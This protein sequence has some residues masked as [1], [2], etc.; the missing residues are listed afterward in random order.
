M[1]ENAHLCGAVS[2][3]YGCSQSPHTHYAVRACHLLRA[4]NTNTTVWPGEFIEIDAPSELLTDATLAI[5]PRIDSVSSS[6]LKPTHTWPQTDIVQSIGGKLRL[7]NSTEEPL[8]VRK[9]DHLCQA[10][11]TVLESTS[12]PSSTQAEPSPKFNAPLSCS[13]ESVH[14]DPDGLLSPS[15][16][17]AFVSLLKEFQLVFDS[18]IPGYNGAAG[19]IEGVV[20]MGP[21][22]PPQRKGRVPQYSRDQLDL[23]QTKFDEL[24]SQGVFR[25][26]EDLKVVVEYLN[27]SFLV[28]KKNGGFRLVTAFTDVGRYSKP[29]PS[30]MPDVDSTLLKIA[31]WKYII[32]SDLS[33]AFYQIPLAKN[34]MKYCGVVTPFKGVRVYT[35]CAMGI[36]GSETA[37]EELNHHSRLDMVP[38]LDPRFS[39]SRS[40]PGFLRAS[41]E[42]PRSPCLCWFVQLNAWP[43]P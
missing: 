32:V 20:N 31:C 35:R 29:Q 43:G 5:E 4:P 41:Q 17:D 40:R 8:L 26:P 39:S 21:V 12:E 24:E 30:L 27:P 1:L 23:L 15:E 38:R 9:N 10:R 28:K 36:P 2:S 37:L 19:P 42:R 11:L 33:Q 16:R 6:H 7:L 3:H 18:R 14:V 34:S 25:R 13:V 22:E